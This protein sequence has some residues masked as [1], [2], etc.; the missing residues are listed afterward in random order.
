MLRQVSLVMVSRKWPKRSGR[1]S[2]RLCLKKPKRRRRCTSFVAI[3]VIGARGRIACGVLLVSVSTILSQHLSSVI[4]VVVVAV[5][6]LMLLLLFLHY[7]GQNLVRASRR[8]PLNERLVA[9]HQS[10]QYDGTYM[11]D[12]DL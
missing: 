1:T 7:H 10:L 4:V 9:A 12:D 2:E 11:V 8:L 5:W 6:P 3:R